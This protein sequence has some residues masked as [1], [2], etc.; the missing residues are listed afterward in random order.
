MLDDH[1]T[2][3]AGVGGNHAHRLLE[4]AADDVLAEVLLTFQLEVVK[5]L[6]AAQVGDTAARHHAFLDRGA[7]GVEGILDAGLLLLHLH[8]GGCADIDH[9]HAADQL[10]QPLLQ[11]LAIVV[12]G[13]ILDLGADLLDPAGQFLLVA[14]AIDDG[15]VVLVDDHA[16][17]G[18]QV[19][20]RDVLQ[21]DAEILGDHLAAG[22]D[23]DILEHG[24][25][26]VTET[27][28]L[29]R[30]HVQGAAQLVDHQGGQG[31]A[32]HV[33][34]DDDERLAHLGHGLE[35][36]QQILHARDLLLVDEDERLVHAHFHPLRVSDKVGREIA[37]VEL[38]TLDHVQAG[39]HGLGFLDR[40]HAFLA[41]L[42]HGLGDDV[43]DGLVVVGG[44]GA[45]LGDFLLLLGRAGD[46]AEFGDHGGHRG[47]DAAL[48]LH[49]VGAG[50]DQLGA[51][52]VDGLGEHG[53]GGGAVTGDI[54]GLGGDFLDHLGA[55][56]LE[57]VL[58]LDLLG[59]GDAVL[60]DDRGAEGLLD[61]HVAALGA[62]GD[63]YRVG[64]GVHPGEHLFPGLAAVFQ[65]FCS[66]VVSLL[67]L[68]RVNGHL[69]IRPG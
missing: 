46:L 28:G 3:A 40:D 24:L 53:G 59:H 5:Y 41:D 64:Q 55:H 15:G 2:L 68:Y 47:V 29:D 20:D 48:D 49:R 50:G 23:G 26:A 17:G 19:I 27:R 9:G 69:W 61:E 43:A 25:A 16:L 51:L 67:A 14:G 39:L 8:L 36:R 52:G 42:V 38:H 11:L 44:D 62:E 1:R 57:L 10:G 30:G 66:H 60:G 4:G 6:E 32:V 7:G 56:V 31:L 12:R 21:L 37:A 22:E 18:A 63:L 54:R 34:G 13:G 33:L 45:D 35:H 58:D 65:F